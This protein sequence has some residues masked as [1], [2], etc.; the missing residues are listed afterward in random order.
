[1]E[2]SVSVPIENAQRPAAVAAA[3]PALDPLAPLVQVPGVAGLSAEPDIPVGEGAHRRLAE[4]DRARRAQALHHRRIALRDP[5][6]PGFGAPG[7][8]HSGHIEEVLERVGNAVQRPEGTSRAQER[9]HGVRL[10]AGPLRGHGHE[11]L[12]KGRNLLDTG[13][14]DLR[15][16]AARQ[17]ARADPVRQMSDGGEGDVLVPR[18]QGTRIRFAP[19]YRLLGT[20]GS[21]A[22]QARIEAG[23][24]RQVVGEGE[25]APIPRV[26][27]LGR[28]V[29]LHRGALRLR[30]AQAHQP[31]RRGDRFGFRTPSRFSPSFEP[32]RS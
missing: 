13:Q 11:A 27:D 4:Q 32:L 19:P 26:L 30:V 2:P 5:V 1:M 14:I 6:G 31:L 12:E 9:V 25:R 29:A 7:G 21:E 8:A 28:Q 24:W 16:A 18:R 23:R 10:G 20:G 3:E 17:F 15:K 22:R